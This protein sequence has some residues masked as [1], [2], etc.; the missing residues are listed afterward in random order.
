MTS[1][2][3]NPVVWM[4]AGSTASAWLVTRM[5]PAVSGPAVFLGMLGPLVA[6]GSS[7][8]AIERTYRDNPA[9]LTGVMV[10]AFAAKMLL[11]G[12]YVAAM[13]VVVRVDPVPFVLSFTAYFLVLYAVQAT[14][15]Q[16]LFTKHAR[17]H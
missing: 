10:K 7:W 14:L 11:F 5:W 9:R 8:I 2:V 16:R 1:V 4:V 12:A 13:L 6:V 17:S 3:Q 15:L